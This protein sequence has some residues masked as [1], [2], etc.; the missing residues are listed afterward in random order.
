MPHITLT[1]V[2]V[3]FPIFGAYGTSLKHVL[4]S[5]VTG[6]RIG[7]DAGVTVIQA[8][9]DISLE[10]R[11]GDRVG[12]MG[13]NGSGKTT[14]LRTLKGV[15]PPQGGSREAVGR[16]SSLVEPVQGMEPEATGWENIALRGVLKGISRAEMARL[17]P[18]IAEF[19]GL[20]DYLSMPVRTYSSGM[21]MRLAFSI[22]TSIRC[23]ILLMDEWLSVGDAEFKEQA[24]ARLREVV[25]RSGI[26]VLASHSADLISRECNRV[27]E[28]RQGRIVR[29]GRL[30]RLVEPV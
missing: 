12:I 29:D 18:E 24:E 14:L 15:F 13:H 7:Q 20:G 27:I 5:S 17:T 23:D 28:L 3:A 11:E 8:L 10:I 2:S 25:D 4:S 1:D 26:L 22:A 16:I 6:G 21:M 30:E 19:S 9:Q